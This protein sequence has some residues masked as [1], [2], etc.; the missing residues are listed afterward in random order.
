MRIGTKDADDNTI[1]STDEF[2]LMLLRHWNLIDSMYHSAY[3]ATSLGVW[4]EKGRLKLLNLLA[5]M[6]F[7]QKECLKPYNAM[8]LF[9]KE[10]LSEKLR[11]HAGRYNMPHLAF[12]SFMR[13]C[14]Y[15]TAI[16]A[17]DVIYSMSSLLDCGSEWVRKYAGGYYDI[18]SDY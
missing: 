16:S 1:T 5:K 7:P 17:S 6:G 9:Y 8:G 11:D 13:R 15:K 3:V 14:G 4:K 2:R 12:P 10:K 18:A